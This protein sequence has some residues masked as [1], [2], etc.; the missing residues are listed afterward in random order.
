M[1]IADIRF[2]SPNKSKNGGIV[3]GKPGVA[4]A[5][6]GR[7][8]V[9]GTGAEASEEVRQIRLVP[10]FLPTLISLS[11]IASPIGITT[12]IAH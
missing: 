6:A 8:S 10:C 11:T 5:G 7:E 12:I 4:R 2:R 3:A 9:I 1:I